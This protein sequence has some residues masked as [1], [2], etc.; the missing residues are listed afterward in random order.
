M[1]TND[2]ELGQNVAG[3]KDQAKKDGKPFFIWHNPTLVHVF[4]YLSPK[5]QVMMPH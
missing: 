4:T 3:S 1:G 5:Y 2:E